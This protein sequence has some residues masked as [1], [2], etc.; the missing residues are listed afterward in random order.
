MTKILILILLP[1][2]AFGQAPLSDTSY[3]TVE[4]HQVLEIHETTYDGGKVVKETTPISDRAKSGLYLVKEFETAA[5]GHYRQAVNIFLTKPFAEGLEKE[6]SAF[7]KSVGVSAADSLTGAVCKM[8]GDSLSLDGKQAT[9]S[10]TALNC[11]G[12]RYVI[13]AYCV[14]WLRLTTG[15]ETTDFYLVQEGTYRSLSGRTLKKL[16]K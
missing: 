10:G 5:L 2:L 14:P 11:D 4:N 6:N 9:L 16:K 12:S 15:D 8:L 1:A 13:T 7:L 3:L